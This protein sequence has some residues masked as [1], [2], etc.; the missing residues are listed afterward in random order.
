MR[1][2]IARGKHD[3]S[4]HFLGNIGCASLIREK[5]MANM[6]CNACSLSYKLIGVQVNEVAVHL[7]N[8]WHCGSGLVKKKPCCSIIRVH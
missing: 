8:E 1:V 2:I 7:V 3:N 4:H 6:I 5:L